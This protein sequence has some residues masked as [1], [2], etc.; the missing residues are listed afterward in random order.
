MD[1]KVVRPLADAYLSEQL[2][3]ETTHA[4]VAHLDRCPTCRA[5]FEAQRRLRVA[6]R[7][8]F[9][10][11]PDLQ[12]RGEFLVALR[13]R[14]QAR[15]E[16]HTAMPIWRSWLGV[17]AGVVLAIGLGGG[18]VAWLASERVAVLARLAAGDHQDCAIKFRLDD[19]PVT[20]A[21]GAAMFDPAF[22][23]LETTPAPAALSAGAVRVLER[24]ACVYDGQPFAH[25]VLHYKDTSVSVLVADHAV[26]GT[27][28][29]HGTAA[30]TVSASGGFN[31]ASFQS[32]GHRVFFVSSLPSADVAEVA[33]AMRA[34][35]VEALAGL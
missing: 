8:A 22:G 33:Q 26:S 29:W 28:W 1:C 2:L 12:A 18:G 17:A 5:D 6:T 10:A 11:A 4:V 3:V 21:E 13:G 25:I 7:L 35:I 20:L 9:E 16:A 27:A 23:R 24:H 30:S 15:S 34:P 32:E 19:R 14:L 31:V